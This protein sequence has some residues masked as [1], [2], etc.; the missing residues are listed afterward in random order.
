MA[1]CLLTVTMGASCAQLNPNYRRSQYEFYLS[2]LAPQALIV[3]EGA[4]Q[5]SIAI[6]DSLGI[7]EIRLRS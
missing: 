3:E 5:P 7:G 2:D 1:A 4:D 6:A